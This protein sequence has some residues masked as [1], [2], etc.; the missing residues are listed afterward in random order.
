MKQENAMEDAAAVTENIVKL[1]NEANM[2]HLADAGLYLG[3]PYTSLEGLYGALSVQRKED[4]DKKFLNRMRYAGIFKERTVNTFKWDDNTYPM[5]AEPGLIE[6]A[7]TLG[8]VRQQKN[9]IM[10]GP[11]GVGKTL[12]AVII[13]CKALREGFSVK[14]KTAHDI[15][16]ELR[17]AR[18]GNSLTGYIKRIQSCDLLVIEDITFSSPEIK[19]A[20]AFFSIVDKRYGRKATIIT[21]NGNIKDWISKYPDKRMCAALLGRMCEESLL[22]NMNDAEDMRSKQAYGLLG[23]AGGNAAAGDKMQAAHPVPQGN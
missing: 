21:T 12:L 8:F 6:Q 23:G 22:L 19:I 10:S 15:I 18:T 1:F 13:A 16:T 9:L 14:Y 20:Q 3:I 4:G 5:L 2:P 11:P 7:L 17:E